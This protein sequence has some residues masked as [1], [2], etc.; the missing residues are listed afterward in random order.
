MIAHTCSYGADTQNGTR[1]T[2][3]NNSAINDVSSSSSP[4]QND[5]PD[6]IKYIL[7]IKNFDYYDSSLL[8][9][10]LLLLLSVHPNDDLVYNLSVLSSV[11][12]WNQSKQNLGAR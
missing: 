2:T 10:I 3:T 8:F 9:I 12:E 5:N 6:V 11:D 1:K 7:E 4:P